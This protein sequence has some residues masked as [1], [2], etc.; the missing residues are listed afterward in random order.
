VP[1]AANNVTIG[2][3]QIV[4]GV[5]IV[6][7]CLPLLHDKIGPNRWYGVR[8][9]KSFESRENW[10]KLNRYGARQMILW[11]GISIACGVVV[12]FLSPY[13][14]RSIQA[15]V[16]SLLPP[17]ALLIPIFRILRYAKKL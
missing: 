3:S 11:S 5:L 15:A 14:S 2:L 17:V 9:P 8:I 16:L 7:A 12:L 1:S 4:A 6:L 13:D 10:F